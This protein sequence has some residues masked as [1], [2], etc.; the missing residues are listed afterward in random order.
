V[1]IEAIA[2]NPIALDAQLMARRGLSVSGLPV[3]KAS[4]R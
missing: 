1:D 4:R 3:T 2:A